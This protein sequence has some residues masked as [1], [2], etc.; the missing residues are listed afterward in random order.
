MNQQPAPGAIK[1]TTAV[2]EMFGR[3]APRYDLMNRLMTGGQDAHWRRL[4]VT[5]A[6]AAD[7]DHFLDVATGTGDLALALADAEGRTVIG[8][9]FAAP[10]IAL[11]EAKRAAR[12]GVAFVVGDA[13]RLPFPDATFDAC[14]IAFGLRNL[15]GYAAGIAEMAR[16]LKPGGRLVCLELTPYR[17]PVLGRVFDVYF[18]QVV[19]RLGGWLSCDREA[20]RYLP[21]SVAAFPTAEQLAALM[22]QTGFQQVTVNKVGGGMVAIHTAVRG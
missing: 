5:A 13:M 19:P 21:S 16:V 15:P 9:D 7:G 3:I 14:T 18:R 22:Q 17:T 4:A 2:R 12:P 8:L 11:A 6:T 10:M 20:Y 1:D